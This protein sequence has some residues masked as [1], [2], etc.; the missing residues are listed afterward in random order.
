MIRLT[1][2]EVALA[3]QLGMRRQIHALR[4]A[5]PDAYG[6][7]DVPGWNDHIEGACGE[8]AAAKATGVYWTPTVD[9]F[10]K[11]GD[12]GQWQ[13]RTRSRDD[14]DLIVRDADA[15][16]AVFILV[17]GRTPCFEVVGWLRGGEAKRPE[18]RHTHGDRPAA[19]FVPAT[20]LQP[21]SALHDVP[22][23]PP[24]LTAT[25]IPFRSR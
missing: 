16:D 21:L 20:A 23:E 17:R 18:W 9:T 12:V 10:R 5:R 15:D 14:Y 22:P 6:R 25:D 3:A 24:A 1:W 8:M 13:V 7:A 4:D 19:Y 11:G 2:H